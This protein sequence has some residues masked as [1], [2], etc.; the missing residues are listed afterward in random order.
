MSRRDDGALD[1][2]RYTRR[3]RASEPLQRLV[4]VDEV[5]AAGVVAGLPAHSVVRLDLDAGRAG[6]E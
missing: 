5:A 2:S 6:P 3:V 4:D 1:A